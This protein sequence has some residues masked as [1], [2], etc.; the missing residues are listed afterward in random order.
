MQKYSLIFFTRN[1]KNSGFIKTY[2][3]N[4]SSLNHQNMKKYELTTI[5][6][7]RSFFKNLEKQYF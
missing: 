7:N 5:N 6:N 1:K 2:N 4:F 3:I